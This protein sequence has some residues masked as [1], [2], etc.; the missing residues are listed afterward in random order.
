LIR[1][2]RKSFAKYLKSELLASGFNF[3]GTMKTIFE[4]GFV[5]VLSSAYNVGENGD[6]A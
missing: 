3:E 5:S 6:L 1:S 4:N 2:A